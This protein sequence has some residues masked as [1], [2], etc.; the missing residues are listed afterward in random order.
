VTYQA[1]LAV[2]Q[3]LGSSMEAL[4]VLSAELQLRQ[5]DES[6]DP[7]VRSILQ[8]A[9]EKIEP[10][11][12]DGLTR[13]QESLALATINSLIRQA[14]DLADNPARAPEWSF[15]DSTILQ[16]IGRRSRRVVQMIND[17]S[18][19]LPEL[20]DVLQRPGAFLDVGTG[21]GWLAIEAA[22]TWPALR[23]V[24]I[25]PWEPSLAL[26][27]QNLID[28]GMAGRIEL[29]AQRLEDLPDRDVFT[30][31]WLPG[32]FLAAEALPAELAVAH[33]ALRVGGWLVFGLFE[34]ST[35]QLAEA[36]TALRV[37]RSGG[38]PWN[39]K[40]VEDQ[41]RSAGFEQMRLFTPPNLPSLIFGK[42]V[43]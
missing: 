17:L 13:D 18:A 19:Q 4:A 21:V 39:A 8:D 40:Q 7:R 26:A 35:D 36:L 11:L 30:L 43:H 23:V 12:L 6:C 24:G 22:N 41:L 33:G 25:D 5:S 42:R 28:T 15:R 14:L 32:P 10:G 16:S 34:P 9:V 38:H 27:R 31:V 20:K 2:V 3:R 29:R 1:L 37:V